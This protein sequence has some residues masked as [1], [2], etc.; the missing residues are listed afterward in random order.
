MDVYSDFYD[1]WLRTARNWGLLV[2]LLD[3]QMCQKCSATVAGGNFE[4]NLRCFTYF[5]LNVSVLKHVH[6]FIIDMQGF[7]IFKWLYSVNKFLV[8]D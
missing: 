3:Q 8:R 2:G 6:K 4:I 1:W 7:G 5:Y